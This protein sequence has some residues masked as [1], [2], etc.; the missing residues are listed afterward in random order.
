MRGQQREDAEQMEYSVWM[1][2]IGRETL[3][4]ARENLVEGMWV[5]YTKNPGE[6]ILTDLQRKE[7][8]R[9]I[10]TQQLDDGYD[11]DI[12]VDVLNQT[13]AAMQQQQQSFVQF[14]QMLMQFPAIAMSP[15]LIRKAASV[16]GMRDENVIHQAQQA[17]ALSMAAKAAQVASQ[18]G[19]TLSQA[20]AG[21]Q[22]A[23]P[24]TTQQQ[25][26]VPGAEQIQTQI[27]NQLPV[28]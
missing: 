9:Y 8:F 4:Q 17:A 13:P 6:T 11:F 5:K 24:S 22:G 28:Q 1:C 3:L 27:N 14:M 10:T 16:C 20:T 15:I 25:M 21:A 12:D 7:V 18:R 23:Q 19:Q 26:Q 2:L